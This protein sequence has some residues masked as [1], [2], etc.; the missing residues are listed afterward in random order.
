[1]TEER[2][3]I[4]EAMKDHPQRQFYDGKIPTGHCPSAR[5]AL[6]LLGINPEE[7]RAD[8]CRQMQIHMDGKVW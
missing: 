7:R 2:K 4:L 3:L 6:E 8:G 5:E 1:M